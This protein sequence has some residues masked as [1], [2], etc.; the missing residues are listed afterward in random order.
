MAGRGFNPAEKP[1]PT[2]ALAPEGEARQGG[3]DTA[4]HSAANSDDGKTPLDLAAAK[5]HK[6]VLNLL[7]QR[8]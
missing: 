2:R 7:R 5:D 6:D 4:L 1:P 8:G 3:G